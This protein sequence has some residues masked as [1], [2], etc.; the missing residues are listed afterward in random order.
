VIASAP[1]ASHHIFTNLPDPGGAFRA[2]T[3]GDR[4]RWLAHRPQPGGPG[5]DKRAS[6]IFETTQQILQLAASEG[7]PPATAAD[8]L[9]ERRMADVGRVRMIRLDRDR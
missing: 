3:C 1:H 4:Y 7:V 5:S 8:R 6:K 2:E 9:A